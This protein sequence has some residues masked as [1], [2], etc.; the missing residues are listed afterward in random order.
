MW[1]RNHIAPTAEDVAQGIRRQANQT[2]MIG[3]G[4]SSRKESNKTRFEKESI[5]I[6]SIE[7]QLNTSAGQFNTSHPI[8]LN[9]ERKSLRVEEF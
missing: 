3:I 5:V 7:S 8:I 6:T 9:P 1:I 2:L 4:I